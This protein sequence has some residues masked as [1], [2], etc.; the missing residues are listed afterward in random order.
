MRKYF[1]LKGPSAL[2]PIVFFL[3]I[4]IGSG[5]YLTIQGVEFAFYKVSASVAILPA[6]ILAVFLG[7]LSLA[8]NISVF[9]EGV[10]EKNIITMC[11]IYLLAGAYTEVLKGIGGVEAT[12]HFALQFIPQEATLPGV[13]IIGAF[14]STS[15]GT[16]MGTIAALAPI[17]V[18]ISQAL[19]INPA[20]MAGA[21]ISGAMFGDN[22]SMI[23]DTTIAATQIHPCSLKDK[24]NINF[25]IALGP[26]IAT[27]I[28]FAFAGSG[29]AQDVQEVKNAPALI[30]AF[31][32]VFV[33]IMALLGINVFIVLSLGLVLGSVMGLLFAPSYTALDLAKNIF[34]GYTSMN[35]ILILSL[36]IGGLSELAKDQGGIRFLV[37]GIDHFIQK[38]AKRAQGS[39][40]AEGAVSILVS[41]CDL[42]TANN[43]V[44]IILA[45]E[46]TLE[47]SKRYH[48]PFA[49][50][51]ALVTIFSCVFQGILPYSA[52]VLLA[53]SIAGVSPLSIVPHVYY[54]YF[55]GVGAVIAILFR[56]PRLKIIPPLS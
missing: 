38:W 7:R 24:F 30:F 31:P 33:L 48:I 27:L 35:E 26:L 42:C 1:T 18:G 11:M 45:G 49:R 36:L 32:Y 56:W 19:G 29:E 25:M 14:V 13:F 20:L 5:T 37:L 44:A 3:L 54:C 21:V 16:S 23:S 17:A 15:M 40:I 6:L 12:V 4:F 51:A 9:L 22:L 2:L 39:R 8:E 50:T 10:R 55:L 46:A 43:T 53:G 52:Q 41:F 34:E 47:I 28:F